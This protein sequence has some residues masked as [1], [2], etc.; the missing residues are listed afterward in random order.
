MK[1][2]KH[3]RRKMEAARSSETLVPYNNTEDLDLNDLL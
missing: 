3:G 1:E 2:L